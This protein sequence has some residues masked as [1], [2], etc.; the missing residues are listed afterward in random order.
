MAEGL[1][2]QSRLVLAGQTGLIRWSERG[3]ELSGNYYYSPAVRGPGCPEACAQR[4]HRQRTRCGG[5][6]TESWGATAAPPVPGT[7]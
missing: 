7:V 6:S 2:G 3:R 4:Y 5:P 1:D